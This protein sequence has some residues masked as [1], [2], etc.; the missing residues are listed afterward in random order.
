MVPSTELGLVKGRIEGNLGDELPVAARLES[1][2]DMIKGVA[3]KL[4]KMESSQKK[5]AEAP[6]PVAQPGVVQQPG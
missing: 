1:L 3:D 2:E 4:A 6:L 5:M